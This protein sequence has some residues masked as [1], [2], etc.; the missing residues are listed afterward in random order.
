MTDLLKLGK[1]LADK[2]PE[3]IPTGTPISRNFAEL[4]FIKRMELGLTQ[5]ELAKKAKV[6][7]KTIHRI[8]GGSGGVTD[9][10]YQKVCDVIGITSDDIAESF[11]TEVALNK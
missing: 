10:T 1:N 8:E 6:G 4:I 9:T 11:R 5:S 7:T 2:N 3:L